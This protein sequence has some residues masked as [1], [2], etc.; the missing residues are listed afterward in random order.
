MVIV[1]NVFIV[2]ENSISVNENYK[3]CYNRLN[4]HEWV[5]CFVLIFYPCLFF[6]VYMYGKVLCRK[7]VNFLGIYSLVFYF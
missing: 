3:S 6:Y 2:N 5:F 1:T 7:N 4:V